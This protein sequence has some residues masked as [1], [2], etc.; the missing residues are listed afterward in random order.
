[1]VYGKVLGWWDD[2][3]IWMAALFMYIEVQTAGLYERM[4]YPVII[5]STGMMMLYSLILTYATQR[6]LY[7]FLSSWICT[8]ITIRMVI[9]PS[10]GA[11]VYA[12]TLQERQQNYITR[13]AHDV[14]L[15]NLN[16][17]ATYTNTVRGMQYKGKS[18]T[19]AANMAA[20]SMKGRVQGR[21]S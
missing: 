2:P 11:A 8:M 5:R 15:V 3:T 20:M 13:Y 16:A 10:L 1:M 7:K 4:K 9:A 12:N 19:E 21:Q 17:A 18:E 6:M 14:D